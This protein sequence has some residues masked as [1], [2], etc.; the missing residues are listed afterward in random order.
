MTTATTAPNI[1]PKAYYTSQGQPDPG[2]TGTPGTEVTNF[3]ELDKS[4][5]FATALVTD[6]TGGGTLGQVADAA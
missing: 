4:Y 5:N 1:R 3:E 6:V 2:C